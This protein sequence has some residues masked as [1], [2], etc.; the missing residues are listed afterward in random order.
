MAAPSAGCAAQKTPFTLQIVTLDNRLQLLDKSAI[1]ELRAE[2]TSVMPH[3][4]ATRLP[5]AD[6]TNLVAYLGSRRERNG[7]HASVRPGGVTRSGWQGGER[8]AELADLLGQLP[9]DALLGPEGDHA[10]QCGH[11][12][13]G[14]DIRDAWR[15]RA[16]DNPARR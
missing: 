13:C 3:D 6:L 5:A 16:A 2:N 8:A 7:S 14:L 9:G 10:S 15:R 12:A 4:F 1:A 11:A